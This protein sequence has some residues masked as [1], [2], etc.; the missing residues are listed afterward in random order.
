MR[1]VGSQLR[2]IP[3]RESAAAARYG[4]QVRANGGNGGRC[5]IDELLCCLT[6]S[7]TRRAQR[8]VWASKSCLIALSE[9]TTVPLCAASFRGQRMQKVAPRC[10]AKLRPCAPQHPQ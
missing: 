8:V 10:Q 9:V 2:R 6:I 3:R 4:M 5:V 1:V 7:C